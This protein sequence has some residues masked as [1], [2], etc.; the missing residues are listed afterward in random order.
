MRLYAFI[1]LL[2]LSCTSEN[3]DSCQNANFEDV[4]SVEYTNP[5]DSTD[6]QIDFNYTI[7]GNLHPDNSEYYIYNCGYPNSN[8]L[9]EEYRSYNS[10]DSSIYFDLSFFIESGTVQTKKAFTLDLESG[11]ETIISLDSAHQNG[12]NSVKL[13]I[14]ILNTEEYISLYFGCYPIRKNDCQKIFEVL[15]GSLSLRSYRIDSFS[16]PVYVELKRNELDSF[17]MNGVP[18]FRKRTCLGDQSGYF[19]YYAYDTEGSLLYDYS[20]NNPE[21][22]LGYN[23]PNISDPSDFPIYIY[24][25]TMEPS[26]KKGTVRLKLYKKMSREWINYGTE[27][28]QAYYIN[29][30]FYPPYIKLFKQVRELW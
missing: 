21:F 29:R 22:L 11:K 7:W 6:Y 19:Y 3:P 18:L 9:N 15:K 12:D 27:P 4:I 5:A 25:C 14:R 8:I 20:A 30:Y 10:S 2:L 13:M 26:N 23:T 17:I 28:T 16:R 1:G 24:Y